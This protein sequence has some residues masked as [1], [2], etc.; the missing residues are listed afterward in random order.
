MNFRILLLFIV[1]INSKFG[2]CQELMDWPSLNES[3]KY[4][5]THNHHIS[6]L[7]NIINKAKLL[8]LLPIGFY[9]T[10]SLIEDL[11][12]QPYTYYYPDSCPKYMTIIV[13]NDQPLIIKNLQLSKYKNS[14]CKFTLVYSY[15]ENRFYRIQGFENNN[16]SD[17]S[18]SIKLSEYSDFHFFFLNLNDYLYHWDRSLINYNKYVD[19]LNADDD[20]AT[21][22]I[23]CKCLDTYD[24]LLVMNPISG[25]G[26]SIYKLQILNKAKLMTMSEFGIM[27]TDSIVKI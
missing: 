25:A 22:E 6:S 18:S 8:T 23:C 11:L 21:F 9:E 13:E 12:N 16:I 24:T 14:L 1:I 10:D 26:D 15:L 20:S 3:N 2:N 7:S 19:Y 17:F 5:F 4:G 27:P